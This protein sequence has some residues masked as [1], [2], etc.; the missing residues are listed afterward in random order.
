MYRDWWIALVDEGTS[1][2]AVAHRR[3]DLPVK[4]VNLS[5]S[6]ESGVDRLGLVLIRRPG[7]SILA[8]GVKRWVHLSRELADGSLRHMAYGYVIPVPQREDDEFETLE[9][10]LA[11]ANWT[12]VV[13]DAAQG[14]KVAGF[15]DDTLVAPDAR[16]EVTEILDGYSRVPHCDR[17]THAVSFPEIT[18]FDLPNFAAPAPW[19]PGPQITTVGVPI[20]GVDVDATA[21]W[22]QSGDGVIDVSEALNESFPQGRPSTLTPDEFER[23]WFRPGSDINGDSGW[24][25]IESTL[26]RRFDLPQVEFPQT[27]GP[28][29]GPSSVYNY[30]RDQQLLDPVAKNMSFERAWYDCTLTLAWMLRQKRSETIRFSVEN[31]GQRWTSGERKRLS[32][33]LEDVARD[34]LTPYWQPGGNYVAGSLWRVGTSVYECLHSHQAGYFFAQDIWATGQN[35]GIVQQWAP[36]I[37][38]QSPLGSRD[39]GTFFPTVRGNLVFQCIVLKARAM[40]LSSQRCVEIVFKH[41]LTD[42]LLDLTTASTCTVSAPSDMLRGGADGVV[43]AK[44]FKY[45]LVSDQDDEWIEI[46]LRACAGSG[47]ANLGGLGIT[48]TGAPW[49]RIV[50]TGF[51]GQVPPPF[52]GLSGEATVTFSAT[53]QIPYVQARDFLPSAGRSDAKVN[54]PKNVVKTCPTTVALFMTQ[55]SGRADQQWDIYVPITG[56]F[57][58]PLQYRVT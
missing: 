29:R 24:K 9:F 15:Y 2:D 52:E 56:H 8:P 28:F 37:G 43:T 33:R 14:L 5:G 31:A 30:V 16:T 46:T 20:D 21:E 54:D 27:A 49:D 38:D 10:N 57:A 36:A 4:R 58:G 6:E 17:R 1:F 19:M 47:V 50:Y 48:L 25:V 35:G 42:E 40:I 32:L 3:R 7:D 26:T 45:E 23:S 11:P 55:L 41:R 12:T 53:D 39:G 51:N 18:G 44:V 22:T 13:R 34:D